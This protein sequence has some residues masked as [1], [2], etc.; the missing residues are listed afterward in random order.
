MGEI[1][2]MKL[3]RIYCIAALLV[4]SLQLS[5][6]IIQ[7][8]VPKAK[9]N[10]TIDGI[11][12]EATWQEK[13]LISEFIPWGPIV[14]E[15]PQTKVWI[16]Q[17]KDALV[18]AAECQEEFP[19]A[20]VANAKHDG[21]VWSDDCME[22]FFDTTGERKSC[23]QL[24][25]NSKAVV[26]DGLIEAQGQS[27]DFNWESNAEVKTKI[28]S[29]RWTLEM[30]VPFAN[31]PPSK[32]DASWTFHITRNR[33][34]MNAMHMTCLH[35]PIESFSDMQK[36]DILAGIN[37]TPTGIIVK[38][39]MFGKCIPGPNTAYAI[40]KNESEQEQAVKL[41]F[42]D[43][44][45]SVKIPAG[46][47]KKVQ[48]HWICDKEMEG[49][50]VTMRV[51]AGD[52]CVITLS[53]P[54]KKIPAIIEP[55]EPKVICIGSSIPAVIDFKINYA[56][57]LDGMTLRW[58]LWNETASELVTSGLTSVSTD[59]MRIRIFKTFIPG[60]FY[61]LRRFLMAS[62]GKP[63]T[64]TEDTVRITTSPWN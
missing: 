36:F 11:L 26:A 17:E 1:T 59:N 19:N 4:A 28:Y 40:L 22:F 35:T 39:H 25:V 13:P 60:G 61:K 21:V 48:I 24:L 55:I 52:K 34:T 44:E 38:E 20:L 64:I 33:Y 62:N 9:D 12:N 7:Y 43:K 16:A 15:M 10:V 63:V 29:D 32:P 18:I 41:T 31:L 8:N 46:D 51:F 50:S 23:V 3:D 49:N 6:Q 54:L 42:E 37:G 2:D 57:S 47:E 58:E 14:S 5:A 27:P 56:S 53:M 30:R 45:V